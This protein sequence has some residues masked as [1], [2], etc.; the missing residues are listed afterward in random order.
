M[1]LGDGFAKIFPLGIYLELTNFY[2]LKWIFGPEA[3][4]IKQKKSIVHY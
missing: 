3:W 4:G 2:F 1:G